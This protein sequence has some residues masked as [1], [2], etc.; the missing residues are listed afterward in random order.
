MTLTTPPR[1]H[2]LLA[3]ASAVLLHGADARAQGDG[4]PWTRTGA[5]T[6]NWQLPFSTVWAYYENAHYEDY[7]GGTAT[8]GPESRSYRIITNSTATSR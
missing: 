7:L 3:I 5:E 1:T 2:R 8:V 6:A 4:P